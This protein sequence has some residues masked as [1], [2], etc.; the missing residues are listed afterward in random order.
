MFETYRDSDYGRKLYLMQNGIFGVDVQPIACQIAKLR[1]FISLTVEQ[2]TNND[3]VRNYGIRP[4]PNLET[5]FVAA[6]ALTGIG[7]GRQMAWENR[8]YRTSCD[9]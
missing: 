2:R 1:F 7:E 6:D 5:R 8:R 4:L 9:A 3:Q